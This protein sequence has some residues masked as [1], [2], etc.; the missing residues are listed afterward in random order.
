MSNYI[1]V[2][3]N[4]VIGDMKLYCVGRHLLRGKTIKKIKKANTIN[5]R[6]IMTLEER[7]GYVHRE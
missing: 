3:F 7:S 6:M 1:Y 5:V 4:L 2:R